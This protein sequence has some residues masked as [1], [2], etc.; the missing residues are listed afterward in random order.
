MKDTVECAAC[1]GYLVRETAAFHLLSTS[2]KAGAQ[3]FDVRC[4]HCPTINR[5]VLD[6]GTV[7]ASEAPN[8]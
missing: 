3:H 1:G 7:K 4:R 2:S 8:G 5:L 6:K